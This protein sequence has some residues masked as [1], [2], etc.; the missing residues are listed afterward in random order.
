M[1]PTGRICGDGGSIQ[2]QP[3]AKSKT[4]AT[5]IL[6]FSR[7]NHLR[8]A[9]VAVFLSACPFVVHSR[10]Q[11][12]S[13][14]TRKSPVDRSTVGSGRKT[15]ESV[16]AGCHGLDGRGGE[17]GPNIAARAEVQKLTDEE[18]RHILQSG[19]PAAGMPAF[20]ALGTPKIKAVIG[21]LRIL[22]GGNDASSI[23]GDPQ[24]GKLL[25][26]G[27]AGC[28]KC[29]MINGAGG[30]LGADLS[31]YASKASIEDIRSEITDPNKDLDPQARTVLVTTREGARF[32]GMA[33]NE[34][35]FSLLLQSPDGTFHLLLKSDLARLEYQPK[36]LMP[37]DY[38]AVLSRA[39]LDDLVNYLFNV[40][41]AARQP[42]A[43]GKKSKHDEEDD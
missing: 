22:Q 40:A 11:G 42:Q 17:R 32:T 3:V 9:I 4:R 12:T 38:G 10:G 8:A 6:F 24:R 35:N 27:K 20:G 37:S 29:H 15:F 39:E 21:Y 23:P 7:R 33:R 13:P 25:F 2:D 43:S 28:A 1:S 5:L 31:S 26:F 30:F 16:C 14:P 41:R 18:T 19:I 36:S 34:D